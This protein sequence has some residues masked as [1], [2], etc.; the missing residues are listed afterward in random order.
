MKTCR[1]SLSGILE[2]LQYGRRLFLKRSKAL[3]G[4]PAISDSEDVP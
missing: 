3:C 1:A 4:F 2:G